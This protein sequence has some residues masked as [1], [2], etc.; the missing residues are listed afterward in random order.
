MGI[1][2]KIFEKR[3]NRIAEGT[4]A[5]RPERWFLDFIGGEPT[6]S[7]KQINE[8]TALNSSAVF[9]CIRILSETVASV[10]LHLYRRTDKGKDRAQ[11]HPLYS[12]LHDMA[13]PEMSSFTWREV[14]QGHLG[15]WGNAYSEVQR[16]GAGN[17]I[18]LWPL[19]PDRT[20]P[21][22]NNGILWYNTI[23]NGEPISIP[24]NR[25]LHIPFFGF[26]G[27][28]GY[29]PIKLAREAI[30]LAM[31]T[32][33]HGSRLFSNDA[34]PGGYLKHPGNLTEEAKKGLRN[35]FEAK[36]QGLENRHRLAVLEEGM[37]FQTVGIPPEDA[38]MLQTRKFQIA[39]IARWYRMQLHKLQ[40]LDRATF[41]NIEQMAIEF[42]QDT[43]YP[44][45]SRWE[46]AIKTQLLTP[47]ER[48]DY[49]AEFLIEGLLRGDIQAR[50]NAYSIARQW[51]WMSANDVR[52]RENMDKLPGEQGDI[53][54]IPANMMPAGEAEQLA[55]GEG[56]NHRGKQKEFEKRTERRSAQARHR[57]SRNYRRIFEDAAQ[58]VVKRETKDVRQ[59]ARSAMG[60]RDEE[61][62]KNWLEEY[63]DEAPK[64]M[65]NTMKPVFMSY[66]EAIYDEAAEEVD[67]TEDKKEE[68]KE[69][70]D[71]YTE[72][73]AKIH[74]NSSRRQIQALMRGA[75][76]EGKE[77]L[78]EVEQRL[79]EW[80]EKRPRKEAMDETVNAGGVVAKF[81]FGA[82]GVTYLKWN[83]TGGDPCP[84][85]EELHGKTVGIDEPFLGE[86]DQL[87]AEGED[88]PM[89]MNRPSFVP[90]V[91]RGCQCTIEPA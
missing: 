77:P 52:E 39:E 71:G 58:R 78:E 84:F 11:E 25:V 24:S 90:P 7:G 64:W 36:H 81:V 41:S 32:E 21:E 13:N 75:L 44:W 6:Y 23:I 30:G 26:D 29:S 47:R 1:F 17:V 35:D 45:F 76:N 27:L 59:K 28:L 37:E 66:G 15:S 57:L 89:E 87:N 3:S 16:D 55:S 50:F 48:Q 5:S 14:L 20:W 8:W 42:V 79:D 34:R 33:E 4:P 86:N 31:A 46:A 65:K 85:C 9:G 68:L 91:H 54:L 74:A 56:E 88:N 22:R 12:V 49:F 69:M 38:Q 63:F 60:Q 83:N 19:L 53:Y 82:A 10:P 51:G 67:L 43:M 72:R 70:I 73:W 2:S 61:E 40:E 18:A 80:E 62:F